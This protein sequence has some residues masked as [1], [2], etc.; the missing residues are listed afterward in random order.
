MNSLV[1]QGDFTY[2]ISAGQFA[3]FFALTNFK[4]RLKFLPTALGCWGED[5]DHL[6][7]NVS[8]NRC[9]AGPNPASRFFSSPV[10]PV[11]D[12]R[13]MKN[14]RHLETSTSP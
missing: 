13:V 6:R 1:Q 7:L 3:S 14:P 11:I 9:E 8:A 4:L 5:S 2:E 12:L 10:L